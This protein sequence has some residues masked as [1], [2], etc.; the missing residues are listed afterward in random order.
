M[1][2]QSDNDIKEIKINSKSIDK[3][4]KKGEYKKPKITRTDKIGA[5]PEKVAQML[6]GFVEIDPKDYPSIEVGTFIRYLAGGDKYRFGGQVLKH[7]SPDYIILGNYTSKKAKLF[8]WT[9]SLK[10]EHKNR[11]FRRKINDDIPEEIMEIYKKLKSGKYK[12][13]KIDE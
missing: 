4:D 1:S 8:T 7:D 10:P 11:L 9:L 3:K 12:L 5:D 2:K 6:N 13:V